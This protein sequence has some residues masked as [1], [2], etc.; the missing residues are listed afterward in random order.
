[1]YAHHVGFALD[2]AGC[3]TSM[4]VRHADF[5]LS[6]VGCG[7]SMS[8][9]DEPSINGLAWTPATVRASKHAVSV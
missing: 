2:L 6:L 9:N 4:H 7:M 3:G 1:M 5:A 8:A